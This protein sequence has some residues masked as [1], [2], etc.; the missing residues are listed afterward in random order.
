MLIFIAIVAGFLLGRVK[1]GPFFFVI[2]FPGVVLH[3]LSHYLVA[4]ALRG[5]PEPISLVPKK[6][7]DGTWVLGSVTFYPSW[8]NAGF[9][10]LAPLYVLPL[11]GWGIYH[12][13][14]NGSFAEM[15]LG[16]YLL[17]C[18]AWGMRPSGADWSIALSRPLGSLV[19]LA[20]V[21]LALQQIG[22]EV[23]AVWNG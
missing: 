6:R 19:V 18:I 15:S 11:L 17:A 5:A 2:A 23:L 16:G 10:A 21:G 9:V 14:R 13:L 7:A 22:L 3:E 20:G 1:S 4:I 8:W 12:A